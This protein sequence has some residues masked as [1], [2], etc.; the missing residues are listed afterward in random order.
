MIYSDIEVRDSNVDKFNVSVKVCPAMHTYLMTTHK[1]I[2]LSVSRYD[3]DAV[4]YPNDTIVQTSFQSTQNV[5]WRGSKEC[6]SF[7]G[8]FN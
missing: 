5:T 7:Q 6:K 8:V 4:L 3:D 2:Q 1:I